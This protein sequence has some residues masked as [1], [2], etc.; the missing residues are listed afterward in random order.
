MQILKEFNMHFIFKRCC[1]SCML[2]YNIGLIFVLQA[3]YYKI[4]MYKLLLEVRYIWTLTKWNCDI[5]L[6]D[7]KG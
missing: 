3:N 4:Q 1:F 7:F 2:N 6:I 5:N